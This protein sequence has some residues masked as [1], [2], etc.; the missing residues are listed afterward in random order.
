MQLIDTQIQVRHPCPLCDLSMAFPDVSMSHWCN[1][2][3]EVLEIVCPSPDQ[4]P[5]ILRKAKRTL[6]DLEEIVRYGNSVLTIRGCH[7]FEFQSVC[8]VCDETN[9]W[10]IPPIHYYGG[11]ET[12]RIMSPGKAS[13]NRLVELLKKQGTVKIISTRPAANLDALESIG[14][15]PVHFFEGLTSRQLH[16]L[17]SAFEK[18]LLDVPAR[19]RMS[20][21]AKE[22]GFSRSTYGEHLRKAICHIVQNS[23]P[24]LKLYDS[25]PNKMIE[26]TP[27]N[28]R[29]RRGSAGSQ[30]P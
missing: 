25:G 12:Y 4:L 7:C 23:Y 21:V 15:I 26:E 9:C 5:E 20:K 28:R 14:T 29:P 10:F 27:R 16:A 18:G 30:Q 19:S 3:K 24:I 8:S 1:G 6:G 17:V 13:L 11:Y 22:E 2:R